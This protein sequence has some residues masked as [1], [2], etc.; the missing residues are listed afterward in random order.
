MKLILSFL[1]VYVTQMAFAQQAPYIFKNTEGQEFMVLTIEQVRSLDNLTEYSPILWEEFDCSKVVD[2][3][4]SRIIKDRDITINLYKESSDFLLEQ[5]KI[6]KDR[7]E[8]QESEIMNKEKLMSI[9]E[10]N[11]KTQMISK[12][13][14]IK[15]HK[16]NLRLISAISIFTIT[17][18]IVVIFGG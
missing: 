12:D 11:Y 4:C 9:K 3:V 7:I 15:K 13:K 6:L 10:E 5:N 2:S 18:L 14:E 1:L 8:F 17:G 16:L